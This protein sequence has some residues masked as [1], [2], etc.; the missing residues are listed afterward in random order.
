MQ[1]ENNAVGWRGFV[2]GGASL[3][4]ASVQAICAAVVAFSGLRV[5]LGM[6]SMIAA[7]A[8]GPAQGFHRSALRVPMLW[9]AGILAVLN[10]ALLWNEERLRRNPAAQWRIQPLTIRQRRARGIQLITS[11]ASILLVIL[12][13]ITHPWFHLEH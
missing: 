8:A 9:L 6:S 1:S 5:L 3:A 10:L 4:L 12:E 7:T 13:I 2:I 11:A